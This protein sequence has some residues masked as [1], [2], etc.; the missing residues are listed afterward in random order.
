MQ[1]DR[2]ANRCQESRWTSWPLDVPSRTGAHK[3]RYRQILLST[4]L[5]IS[6]RAALLLGFELAALHQSTLTLL[7][8]PPRPTTRRI[9]YGLDAIGLLHAA[10]EDLRRTSAAGSPAQA[11]RSSLRQF[12]EDIV[13]R[14]LLDNVSWRGLCRP[15]D[16][17]ETVV[18]CV[19]EFAVELVIMSARPFRW[20]PPHLPFA[21][22]T[23]GR[24][25]QASVL[26]V[27]SQSPPQTSRRFALSALC[28]VASGIAKGK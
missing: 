21:A 20:W 5:G 3:K 28:P 24:R 4:S 15:G 23:I 12:V 6:D 9:A 1:Y 10:V 22:W 11:A 27:R 16:L 13:P 8:V 26:M 19:N 7:H 25:V 2:R 14:P 18:S 17:V